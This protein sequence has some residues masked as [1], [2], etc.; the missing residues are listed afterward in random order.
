MKF[1]KYL[2][3]IALFLPTFSVFAQTT[4]GDADKE[5]AKLEIEKKAVTLLEQIVSDVALLK[6]S[7]NRA[8]VLASAG[9]LLW[10]R[11]EKRARALFRQAADEIIAAN[12]APK[13]NVTPDFMSVFNNPSPRKQILQTVAKYDAELALELLYN[14]RPANVAAALASQNQTPLPGGKEEK[15]TPAMMIENSQNRFLATDE[16]QLEQ[17]FA[18][19]AADR[20]PKKAAKLLR[21]SLAKYGVTNSTFA[22][23]RKINAKDNELA[24]KLAE[25]VG[26]KLLDADF[27]KKT[28]NISLTGNFLKDFYL[29][30]IKPATNSES[31]AP[32]KADAPKPIKIAAKLT[33]DLANKIADALMK[34]EIN[35]TYGV[36][37]Q[38]SAQ[39][40]TLEKIIPER[41]AL[42]KQKQ[43]TLKKSIPSEITMYDDESFGGENPAP[44]KTIAR[45]DK[46]QG[47]MRGFMYKNAVN[48]AVKQG[49]GEK[50]RE[51]LNKSPE[52]K[53]R[54]EA[55]SYLDSKI[56]E[57]KIKDGKIEEA[58]AIIDKLTSKKE[59][60][61]R[62]VQMAVSFNAKA[63]KEDKETAAKLMEDARNLIDYTPED[64]DGINDY[65]R[66]SSGY[67]YI[68]TKTAF[69]MLETFSD[70]VNDIVTASAL[71]AKYDKRNQSFKNGEMILT[72]GLP[73]LG[74]NILRYGKELNLLANDDFDRLRNIADKFQR[75][76]ARIL[77]R[78]YI[79]QAFFTEK[80]GLGNVGDNPFS[81][82]I[83]QTV[84]TF[85]N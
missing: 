10:K 84:L 19:Q 36:Y 8:L 11:D 75:N 54:D 45:A 62:L 26:L 40:K 43:A 73:R 57:T 39:L 67:A 14:T 9:D 21:E 18:S 7:D 71:L 46:M 81:M 49:N 61:E 28:E 76:D 48:D 58:R 42:L 22:S 3:L 41:I 34:I 25:E 56:A 63:T 23:L 29:A 47:Q 59:K 60:V 83:N 52:S 20:D 1:S 72:R 68:E 6:L 24:T 53:D 30:E 66:I 82:E 44:E 17:S 79:V 12:N 69:T 74:R 51:A 4:P 35:E 37:F 5:K 2:L 65:L 32:V 50:V 78:L 31:S 70:Q 64:E 27:G 77:L 13:D 85:D 16:I 38:F 55:L 33:K 15:K 80:I